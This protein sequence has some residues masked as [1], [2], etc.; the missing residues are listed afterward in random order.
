MSSV[1]WMS[2]DNSSHPIDTKRHVGVIVFDGKCGSKLRDESVLQHANHWQLRVRFYHSIRQA[3]SQK[4][5]LGGA[6]FFRPRKNRFFWPNFSRILKI[7]QN[8][9]E[10]RPPPA[11][12]REKIWK[13]APQPLK[14]LHFL[15]LFP[16]KGGGGHTSRPLIKK[17]TFFW[18]SKI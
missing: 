16:K 14:I 10:N 5:I 15:T 17:I 13:T 6:R 4:K 2:V 3:R 7:I 18:N 8:R 1:L 12:F 11:D 9:T